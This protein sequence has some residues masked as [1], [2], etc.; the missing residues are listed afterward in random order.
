MKPEKYISCLVG[1]AVAFLLSLGGMGCLVSAF[2]MTVSIP[3]LIWGCGILSLAGGFYLLKRG[4]AIVACLGA[5]VL[6]WL[7]RRGSLVAG[8]EKLMYVLSTRYD[9]GYG[10]GV[11]GNWQGSEMPALLVLAGSIA[12]ITVRTICRRDTAFPAL[13]WALIPLLLCMVVTDTV[14]DG[15][16]LFLLLAGILILLLT[17]SLRRID[18]GQAN[19][20]TAMAAIP[21]ALVL[22]LVFWLAPQDSYVSKTED[23]RDTLVL[24]AAAV[25]ELWEDLT[26]TEELVADNDEQL[27]NIDLGNQ[28]PRKQFTYAV[29]DVYTETGGTLYLRERD[30]DN[31]SGT[32]WTGS[33]GRSETFG[34]SDRVNWEPAGVVII[35]TRRVRNVLFTPYY[36]G[37][38]LTLYGGSLPNP[39]ETDNYVVDRY[40]LPENWQ[41]RVSG[42]QNAQIQ[43][44]VATAP[45]AD[46][47]R[48]T[49]LPAETRKWAENLLSTILTDEQTDT[50]KAQSIAAYVRRSAS[51]DLDTRKMPEDAT[52]F[53]RWFLEESDTGYCVHFAT[54]AAV[55]LR[56][57]GVEARYVT[58]YM[59]STQADATVTV[60]AER[61]HA[62]VEYYESALD[63][64]IVLEAT[65]AMSGDVGDRTE[66][67]EGTSSEAQETEEEAPVTEPSETELPEE[68]DATEPEPQ[69]GIGVEK[70]GNWLLWLLL[71][72]TAVAA[73]Y[74]IRRELRRRRLRVREPNRRCLAL[75]QE[76]ELRCRLLK[77]RPPEVLEDLARKAK[78]S[79]HTLTSQELMVLES[80]LRDVTRQIGAKSWYLR[81][82][83]KVIWAI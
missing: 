24:W 68:S 61:S 79:Q 76:V 16:Y 49:K 69:G 18:P 81:L 19:T 34:R 57:A 10:W 13:T 74:G 37:E 64:W 12:L 73:Q 5:L 67:G 82:I 66:T 21:V 51:Y 26:G 6:G 62:W 35:T 72:L 44:S 46:L 17:G 53:A 83:W 7:W 28:G 2:E 3:K 78:F 48:Y 29:M 25:P 20:L 33:K 31:Y 14:P 50:E 43:F 54:A 30:Y 11:V 40:V 47:Q 8:F 55:L 4:D 15:T 23:I 58:G 22:A 9:G 39:E 42:G 65:P 80:G 36:S 41:Q 45:V 70:K 60:T 52:D 75:W 27:Q 1:V 77:Q 56:A 59:V 32:G 63:T 38:R 71:P